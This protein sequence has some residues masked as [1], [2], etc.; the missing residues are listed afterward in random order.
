[1]M[2]RMSGK[3]GRLIVV[4]SLRGT[5]TNAGGHIGTKREWGRRRGRGLCEWHSFYAWQW[6]ARWG[7]RV[8]V[9]EWCGA[10]ENEK[11]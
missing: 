2:M 5:E 3:I 9:S 11:E 8:W 4:L 1:M 10:G 6:C 7:A